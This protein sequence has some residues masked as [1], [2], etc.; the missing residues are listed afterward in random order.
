MKVNLIN[1]IKNVIKE[2]IT[3]RFILFGI[4]LFLLIVINCIFTGSL[5]PD[6]N[7]KDIWFY[8]GIFM[9]LFSILFIEP[10]YTVI[11]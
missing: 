1:N 2:S 6:A 3:N 9:V 4:F 5:L 10:Y 8:S 11:C 7:V